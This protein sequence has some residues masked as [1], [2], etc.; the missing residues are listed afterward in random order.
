VTLS[1][2]ADDTRPIPETT[3]HGQD[4]FE[5]FVHATADRLYR[6][7]MLLCRDHHLAEDLTQTT[8]ATVYA[9]W[10]T[11]SRA[12]SPLAYTRMVL[13]RTFL[14]HRRLRRS[15]ERPVETMVEVAADDGDH[16]TRIDLLSALACLSA[17]D[18]A[19]VVLRY[20][21]DLSVAE[22][23]EILGVRQS[24]CRTRAARALARLRTLLPDLTATTD[25]RE[26]RS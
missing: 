11:V 20:W 1:R 14:S 18:R 23:A 7:A 10:S 2:T 12:D 25:D 19:V 16:T 3:C 21:E 4:G 13:M 24:T 15:S 5:Q 6:S 8:Y 9:R 22:V 17:G 26:D